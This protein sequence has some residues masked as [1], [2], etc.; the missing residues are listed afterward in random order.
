[1]RS[2]ETLIPNF[3]I[4]SSRCGLQIHLR[5]NFAAH[6]PRP[7]SPDLHNPRVSAFFGQIAF[8]EAVQEKGA[9]PAVFEA[10]PGILPQHTFEVSSSRAWYCKNKEEVWPHDDVGIMSPIFVVQGCVM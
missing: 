4:G 1:M 8:V 9:L 10:R 2:N 5:S 6:R 3:E 7:N